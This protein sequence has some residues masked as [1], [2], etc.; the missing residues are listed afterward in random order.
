MNTDLEKLQFKNVYHIVHHKFP[1]PNIKDIQDIIEF[2]C[3][4]L[5]Y[6][7]RINDIYSKSTISREILKK[8][9]IYEHINTKTLDEYKKA[10]YDSDEFLLATIEKYRIQKNKKKPCCF[11]C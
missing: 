10:V 9:F 1:N 7:E 8:M 11:L 3:Y 5:F 2:M 4:S 6:D